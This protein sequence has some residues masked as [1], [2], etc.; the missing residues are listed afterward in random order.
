VIAFLLALICVVAVLLLIANVGNVTDEEGEGILDPAGNLIAASIAEILFA[1]W[2]AL[3]IVFILMNLTGKP[4][5]KMEAEGGGGLSWSWPLGLMVLIGMVVIIKIL[6]GDGGGSTGSEDGINGGGAGE[7][8]PG[9]GGGGAES[10]L[11]FIT[12]AVIIAVLLFIMARELRSRISPRSA[13]TS[14]KEM[15]VIIESAVDSLE[16]GGDPR[17]VIYRSYLNMCGLLERR[18]LADISYL[19]PGEF[20]SIAIREFHLPR[21]QVEELTQLFEEARYSDHL[22]GEGMKE[23][24]IR[25]LGAIRRSLENE[26]GVSIGTAS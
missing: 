11:I 6:S 4:G 24:S 12:T 17:T 23:R 13:V 21:E 2:I 5:T 16:A 3:F 22:V 25:C 8:I 20:A 18:G 9:T 26:E 15:R 10:Y 7:I 19:T 1:V 14:D